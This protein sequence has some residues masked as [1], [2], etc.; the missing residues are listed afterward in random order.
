M[1]LRGGA[2][3]F[4]LAAG[5]LR[6]YGRRLLTG[7]PRRLASAAAASVTTQRRRILARHL[8]PAALERVWRRARLERTTVHGALSAACLLAAAGEWP[9]RRAVSL[10]CASMVSLRER[11]T[12]PVPADAVGLFVSVVQTDHRVHSADG[13]W[14]LARAVTDQLHA[15]VERGDPLLG[16]PLARLLI[17]RLE[18]IKD[19]AEINA[20]LAAGPGSTFVLSNLGAV[21]AQLPALRRRLHALHFAISPLAVLPL[22]VAAVTATS[23]LRVTFTFVEPILAEARAV[24]IADRALELLAAPPQ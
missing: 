18:R 23:S 8:E 2:G 1:R 4:G 11:L 17:P 6:V 20:R 5:L 15:A 10:S 19:A 12:P 16:V 14:P 13:L 7:S 22:G 9:Q 24:A 3:V 21:D